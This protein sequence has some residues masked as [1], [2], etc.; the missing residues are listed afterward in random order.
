MAYIAVPDFAAH[1]QFMEGFHKRYMASNRALKAW[2]QMVRPLDIETIA[3]QHG[4]FFRGKEMVGQFLDWCEGLACG[5][6]V[7]EHAYRI[8]AR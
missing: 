1:I 5:I 7:M 4:A 8:P 2:V 6:D 3:P